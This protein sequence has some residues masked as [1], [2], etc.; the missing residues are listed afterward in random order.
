M[1]RNTLI[2]CLYVSAVKYDVFTNTTSLACA[3]KVTTWSTKFAEYGGEIQVIST[4]NA[5]V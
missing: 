1:S 3:I 5:K 2:V 4:V